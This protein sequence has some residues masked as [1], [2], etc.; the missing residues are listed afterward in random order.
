LE[1]IQII[2]GFGD[3]AKG[4]GILDFGFVW[5]LVLGIW[6][7]SRGWLKEGCILQVF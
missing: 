1:E 6:N 3:L 4:F 2:G 5:N 7:L